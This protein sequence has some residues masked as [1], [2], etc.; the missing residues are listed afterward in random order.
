MQV[1]IIIKIVLVNSKITSAS[2]QI[3]VFFL[4]VWE[5][6]CIEQL[7]LKNAIYNFVPK[8]FVGCVRI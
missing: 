3:S 7:K 5:I 6:F 8:M 2:K 1:P 4:Q